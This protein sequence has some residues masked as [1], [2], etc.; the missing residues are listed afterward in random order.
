MLRLLSL[1]LFAVAQGKNVL[2]VLKNRATYSQVL[3]VDVM[4]SGGGQTGQK[5]VGCSEE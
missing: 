1:L 5:C 2:D 3:S 4:T